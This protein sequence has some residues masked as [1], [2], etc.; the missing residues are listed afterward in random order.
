MTTAIGKDIVNAEAIRKMTVQEVMDLLKKVSKKISED[1]DCPVCGEWLI[2]LDQNGNEVESDG[3]YV[4]FREVHKPACCIG[5]VRAGLQQCL[6]DR[7][8]E[9]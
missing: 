8:I 7:P 5:T 9:R 6:C 2:L 1:G 3:D 4:A